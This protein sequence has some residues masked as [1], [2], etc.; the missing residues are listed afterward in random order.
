M[1][2]VA[3]VDDWDE[4][5]KECSGQLQSPI[6]LLPEGAETGLPLKFSWGD[7]ATQSKLVNDGHTLRLTSVNPG[8]QNRLEGGPIPASEF[9]VLHHVRFHWG[10]DG[11]EGSEHTVK[12]EAFAGEV[13]LFYVNSRY[14]DYKR[15]VAEPEG[16]F[17][18]SVLL[19]QGG[20]NAELANLDPA[21]AKV[22]AGNSS[23]SAPGLSWRDIVPVS[24]SLS[25]MSY[26][27]SDTIPP[28]EGHPVT[29]IVLLEPV[30]VSELQLKAFRSLCAE[31]IKQ[32]KCPRPLAYNFRPPQPVGD[33][34]G[35]RFRVYPAGVGEAPRARLSDIKPLPHHDPVTGLETS[36]RKGKG[37]K[38]L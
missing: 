16:M 28:C 12:G 31:P 37:P 33:A 2:N 14:G 4:L 3:G 30:E 7:R 26:V 17:A 27:G 15:A 21:L 32:G 24:G 35:R 5:F 29:W 25:Y 19:K 38:P 8:F 13:Q 36:N 6:D 18:V 22:K 1:D 11:K 23:H 20:L 34:A 10:R 9:G